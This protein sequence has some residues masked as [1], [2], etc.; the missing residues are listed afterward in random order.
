MFIK[1]LFRLFA[2]RWL[3]PR[4]IESIQ[5][6]GDL[7]ASHRPI[8]FIANHSSWWDGLLTYYVHERLLRTPLHVLMDQFQLA[9]RPLFT[10]LGAF[11]IDKSSPRRSLAG[12][13]QAARYL[14]AGESVWIFPQGDMF[15][16]E[17]RP[18]HIHSGFAH[19]LHLAPEAVVVPVSFYY[20]SVVSPKVSVRIAFGTPI[21]KDW[22]VLSRKQ[23]ADELGAVLT[24]QLDAL[25]ATTIHHV[26]T[27]RGNEA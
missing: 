12:L 4:H 24:E 10:H 20:S 7:P 1:A 15:H 11:G 2:F 27:H 14:Q 8:V 23:I 9:K 25:R 19:V 21:E 17:S 13:Q 3:F 18:L 5:I 22:T 26:D 6:V 16:L